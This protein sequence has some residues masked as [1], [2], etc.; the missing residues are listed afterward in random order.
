MGYS[1]QNLQRKKEIEDGL[2]ALMQEI[3]Y[4]QITVKDL[5]EH[6]HIARKTFYHYFSNKCDCL[7]SLTERLLYEC[8]LQVMQEVPQGDTADVCRSRLRYWIKHKA[9]L[10]AINRNKLSFFFLNRTIKYIRKEEA[11]LQQSLSTPDTQ[12]DEDILFFYMSGQI[13]LLL[14]WS[15][16]GFPLSL[17]EMV[18]K[19]LRLVEQPLIYTKP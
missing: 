12:Y 7:K 8:T 5:T 10:D 13:F 14:K 1:E 18:K 17:E 16:E 19:Y 6:L 4:D 2:L 3:P 11:N 9:F 15:E